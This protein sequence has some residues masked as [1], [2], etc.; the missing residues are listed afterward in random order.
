MDLPSDCP[1]LEKA[2]CMKSK[3]TKYVTANQIHSGT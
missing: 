2:Q 3:W 1:Y